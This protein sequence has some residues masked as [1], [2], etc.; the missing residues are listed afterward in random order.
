MSISKS[1]LKIGIVGAGGFA[2]FASQTFLKVPGV[3]IVAIFDINDKA[4]NKMAVEFSAKSYTD[5][6]SFLLDKNISLVYIATPP[7]LHYSQS[8]EALLAGKHVIC[9]KPAAIHTSEAEELVSLARSL[10]L[11][12]V[13]D[14]MQRYNPLTMAVKSMI[15]E[16]MLGEFTHGFFENYA[17]DEKLKPDHWFWDKDKSGGIFIEH[18]IHFFDLF[19]GWLGKGEVI[20]SAQWQRPNVEK[21]MI[22][23]VQ[24][25]VNYKDGPVNFYHG[26]DQPKI[27]D[28]QEIRL[29]FER[30]D[31]TLYEW[32]PVK[33]KMHGLFQNEQIEKLRNIFPDCSITEYSNQAS[34]SDYSSSI[35]EQSTFQTTNQEVTGRFKKVVFDRL[36]TLEYG[37]NADK[38][39]R[40]EQILISMIKDQ[41]NWMLDNSVIRIIDDTNAVESLRMA[42]KAIK[43]AHQY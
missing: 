38:K 18:G 4:C 24:A 32:V 6:D 12:Y 39:E 5:Y 13:V 42:E 15:E 23:R 1:E 9:E 36:L 3:K 10:K 2:T 33:I 35:I 25:I 41:W 28:R 30:G 26:F 17:N 20:H 22:D 21:R 27:L 8:K 14:L 29:Q 31:I 7:Y 37:N 34:D 11:L 19:S 16:K 43:M 40:Y